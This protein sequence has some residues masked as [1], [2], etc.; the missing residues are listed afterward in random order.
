MDSLDPEVGGS[1]VAYH[2]DRPDTPEMVRRGDV[3]MNACIHCGICATTCATNDLGDCTTTTALLTPRANA[4]ARHGRS[5]SETPDGAPMREVFQSRVA[6][7]SRD[8]MNC[9]GA[10]SPLVAREVSR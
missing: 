10:L 2:L 9:A 7:R 6:P 3:D 5:A 1:P 8:G 4:A